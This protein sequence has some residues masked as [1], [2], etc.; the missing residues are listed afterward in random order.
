M[1][2]SHDQENVLIITGVGMSKPLGL[3][4]TND[5]LEVFRQ[6]IDVEHID[7]P[8]RIK[9]RISAINE[10]VFKF[11]DIATED[12]IT[13]LAILHDGDGANN[14]KDASDTETQF[15][16]NY[17]CLFE[18]Y[19]PKVNR[20]VL[21]RHFN[22]YPLIYDWLSLKSI[23]TDLYNN[24]KSETDDPDNGDGFNLLDI[25]T[26]IQ[27]SI[28][29]NIT[30]ATKELFHEETIDTKG[31]YYC[32]RRRLSGA[33][34]VYRLLT[35]K[36]FKH[37]LR[38]NSE[39]NRPGIDTYSN[40]FYEIAKN[41][42]GL[43]K[44][45]RTETGHVR[46][47]FLSNIAYATYN[48]D[49]VLPFLGMK[50]CKKLNEELYSE[51]PEGIW[52]KVYFDFGFPFSGVALKGEHEDIPIFMMG[53]DTAFQINSFTK[54]S[55]TTLDSVKS[56]ILIKIIKAFIPH[57]LINLRICPRCQNGLFI[58]PEKLSEFKFKEIVRLMATDPF[59]SKSD[60]DFISSQDGYKKVYESYIKGQPDEII[61]PKCDHPVY[62]EHSFMEI[63]SLVKPEKPGCAN[64]IK[65]DFGDFFSKA[66]HIISLGYS[67]PPDDIT[68]NIF[69][70]TMKLRK[71]NQG[72]NFKLSFLGK[73]IPDLSDKPWH[74]I[75]DIQRYIEREKDTE[76]E[77]TV[78]SIKQIFS[79]KN[80]RLNFTGLPEAVE[81]LGTE[82]IIAFT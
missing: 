21:K 74:S 3:P 17:F 51:A 76:L 72:Q 4:S 75:D 64:Q 38:I 37:A 48:W 13:T 42:S 82:G 78:N 34:N 53:E 29:D 54:D 26:T 55:Y 2:N 35:Y 56:M 18:K 57:G 1:S 31:I 68:N 10:N 12:F 46:D 41:H 69:Y 59:P 8:R 14:E 5:I 61:C 73:P 32:D 79:S 7:E 30:I 63:Q 9:E 58:F 15:R 6:L 65:F 47:N 49:P 81:Y 25:L 40:F 24:K 62:F 71:D 20:P 27:N 23:A 36:L 67:F 39:N 45:N 28:F 19:F 44:L 70:K 50:T 16:E 80:V 77:R 52:K 43:K 22:D 60:M 33:L 11:D 66:N